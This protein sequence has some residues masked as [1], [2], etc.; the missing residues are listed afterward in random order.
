MEL[1]FKR[2]FSNKSVQMTPEQLNATYEA[3][4]KL[5]LDELADL[6]IHLGDGTLAEIKD[7]VRNKP[8]SS[9]VTT[10]NPAVYNKAKT[11]SP[12]PPYRGEPRQFRRGFFNT[13]PP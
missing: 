4:N 13:T 12:R 7:D 1:R 9:V 2:E 10:N 11:R 6:I 8:A 5:A 3:I